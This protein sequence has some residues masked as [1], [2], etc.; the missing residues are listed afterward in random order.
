MSQK[1][2]NFYVLVSDDDP[3]NVRYV[4]TTTKKVTERFSQHKYNA[5]HAEKRGLP[6]HKWM[7]SKYKNGGSIS[8]KKIDECFESEWEEREQYW[9][10]YYKKL[11]YDLMNLDK[12]GKGV[13]TKEKRSQSSIQRS[14][15]G[16]EIP[17]VALNMDGS[18]YKEYKSI[19]IA[20][21][22]HGFKS[23]SAIGN[24]LT[25]ISKSA[26]N[27]IW[28]YKKDYDPNKIYKYKSEIDDRR[29]KV[30]EFD[31]SGNLIKIWNKKT[32]FDSEN[33]YSQNGV[34]AAIKNKKVYKDSYFSLDDHIDVSEYKSPYKI[35]A[36]NESEIKYFKS[37]RA[38]AK[39]LGM[40]ESTLC[41]K[42]KTTNIINN[43]NI[44]K[45]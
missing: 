45:I 22:E 30:Y 19:A 13:I 37:Q 44:T 21:Q 11:G 35:K 23:G 31:L 1:I 26:G 17:V 36:F 34:N 41:N 40:A 38:L 5:I 25:G 15:A 9:I 29:I 18:F 32:D 20:S 2:Y 27:Y 12:G 42:L 39:F 14:I 8:V 10:S 24:A 7:Y 3:K 4:G 6:V 16:H 28:V 43:Y 33:G